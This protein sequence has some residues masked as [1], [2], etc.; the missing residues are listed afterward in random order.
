MTP[1]GP[2]LVVDTA[3]S[4]AVIAVA[5]NDGRAIADDRWPAGHRHGEELLER[6]DALLVRAHLRL[7]D[8]GGMIVGTGPGA[9]TGLRVGIATAKGIAH[10]GSLPIVG[11]GT[12][13]ALI[14]AASAGDDRSIA[15]LV[16]AGPSGRVLC[17]RDEVPRLLR[18]GDEP[19]S[20]PDEIRVAVDLEGRAG[21][22]EIRLGDQARDRLAAALTAIGADR[23]GR[24][25]ADD[26]ATLVPEYVTLPRGVRRDVPDAAVQVAGTG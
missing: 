7:A 11:V 13:A 8:L 2:L 26:L 9:F 6:V 15:L 16:P 20:R 1:G 5:T 22:D 25:D 23:L 19:D 4:V 10:A 18:G 21:E 14:R 3:T 12:A 24:G 17:R